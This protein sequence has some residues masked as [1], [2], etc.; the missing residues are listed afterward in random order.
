[1]LLVADVA[2]ER[3]RAMTADEEKLW[4]IE[5]LNVV[6]SEIPAVTHVDYSARIQTVRRDVEPALLGD[7]RRVPPPDRLPGHRQ[8]QLQRPRRADRLHA[9]RTATAASC[10]PRSTP[11]SS[12]PAILHKADQPPFEDAGDWRSQF[13][14]D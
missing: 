14:L 2:P 6:R 11:S 9:P 3:R 4:G 7:P 12:R 13:K 8:H 5:K 10:A 1:M